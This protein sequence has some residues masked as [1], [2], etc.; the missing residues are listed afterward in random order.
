[1][2]KVTELLSL[3]N[4][5]VKYWKKLLTSKGRKKERCYLLEGWHLVEEALNSHVA[6]E[7]FMNKAAYELYKDR[8]DVP[9]FIVSDSIIKELA[10]TQAT[11]SV[12]CVAE[13]T[14]PTLDF[15][16]GRYLL[17]DALQDPGNVGTIIRTADA[18]GF[19]GVVLGDA[20][21]DIYNDK[22]IRSMQGSQFHIPIIKANLLS[23]ID[24]LQQNKI[25]IYA[26]T[27]SDKA[28]LLRD[29]E[30][31]NSCAIVMGNE[32]SGVSKVVQ[33]KSD[34]HVFI[35]MSGLAES[36]NVAVAAGIVMYHFS[37]EIV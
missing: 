15:T 3:Q 19:D 2:H 35:E 34:Y 26:T 25:P 4:E 31:I 12:F 29:I 33:D 8:I 21:V 16:K 23:V 11:Q 37:K 1:M 36:L 18:M 30:P 13:M 27:L 22:T 20:T 10:Q 7:C 17:L 6:L 14:M 32:G 9:V 24:Q 28:Q 5:R